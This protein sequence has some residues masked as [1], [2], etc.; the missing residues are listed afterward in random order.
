[1]KEAAK[2]YRQRDS[3]VCDSPPRVVQEAGLRS[4]GGRQLRPGWSLDLTVNDPETGKPWDLS[5]GK[6][7]TKVVQFIAEGKPYTIMLSPMCT[8]FSLIQNVNQARRDPKVVR[9][10]L[11]DKITFDGR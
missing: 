4:Y 9:K 7:R 3:D 11:E 5:C 10:E 2:W 6:I 1:M 8:A